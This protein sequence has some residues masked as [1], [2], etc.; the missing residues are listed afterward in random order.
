M[1][2]G[3]IC[4]L[5]NLL[6]SICSAQE[7]SENISIK[8]DTI[9]I[10]YPVGKDGHVSFDN[11]QKT[12]TLYVFRKSGSV[13]DD[14]IFVN[15]QPSRVVFRELY[16]Y[17]NGNLSQTWTYKFY[18]KQLLRKFVEYYDTIPQTVKSVNFSFD[19]EPVGDE[20]E[21]YL[22]GNLKSIL[23]HSRDSL[24]KTR[25]RKTIAF[26]S[27][28]DFL[29]GI[30]LIQPSAL[31]ASINVDKLMLERYPN[32]KLKKEVKFDSSSKQLYLF[33]YRD[34]G[35]I[36]VKAPLKYGQLTQEQLRQYFI[37]QDIDSNSFIV[38]MTTKDL[39][40][41]WYYDGIYSEYGTNGY[42]TKKLFK[43]GLQI[44]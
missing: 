27:D 25:S 39:K 9:F 11:F 12:K 23:Y 30:T 13:A 31:E 26:F 38:K 28:D 3:R 33:R 44:D 37:K 22:N 42:E 10:K 40:C 24:G 8:G 1:L 4:L 2:S 18:K 15:K 43:N 29:N 21:Y 41:L 34:D 6:C 5:I 14:T 36:I 7:L 17:D 32:G 20:T 19:H 16:Y 35:S